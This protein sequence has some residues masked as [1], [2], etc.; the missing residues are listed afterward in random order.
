MTELR[1]DEGLL[2]DCPCIRN[3]TK[4]HWG[5]NLRRDFCLMSVGSLARASISSS[6]RGRI[7]GGRSGEM[8]T[9]PE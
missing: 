7:T 2:G 3:S 4:G 1:E 8:D 5:R 9:F 6:F